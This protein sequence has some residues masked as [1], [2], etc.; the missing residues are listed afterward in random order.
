MGF[1]DH[2]NS[3]SS[4]PSTVGH[5]A[6]FPRIGNPFAPVPQEASGRAPVG[7]VKRCVS[8]TM[9][10]ACRCETVRQAALWQ[11]RPDPMLCWR[12]AALPWMRHLTC[13]PR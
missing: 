12:G 11:I 8:G 10:W 6:I 2:P 4:E 5:A 1:L 13:R 3:D 9:A 7:S